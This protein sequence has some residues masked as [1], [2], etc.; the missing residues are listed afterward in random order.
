LGQSSTLKSW[1]VKRQQELLF[2]D[3]RDTQGQ[4]EWGSLY[5]STIK[6][7]THQGGKSGPTRRTFAKSGALNGT[8]DSN[9]RSILQDEPVFALSQPV[10]VSTTGSGTALFTIAHVQDL[11]VQFAS[12]P[13]TVQQLPPLWSSSYSSHQDLLEF[14]YHD[15]SGVTTTASQFNTQI[16]N[17]AYQVSSAQGSNFAQI[18]MLAARQ[19]LGGVAF[20]GT[21]DNTL[22]FLKE[23]SSDGNMQTVDVIFP[24]YPFFLYANPTWLQQL[25]EPLLI[26]QA[27]GLYPNKYSMHD[28]GSS[29][30]NGTGHPDGKDEYMPVEECGNMLIMGASV[31]RNFMDTYPGDVGRQ[32]AA[33][34][35]NGPGMNRYN[36]WKQWTGYLVEFSL[37]PANQCMYTIVSEFKRMWA[38]EIASEHG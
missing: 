24:S 10:Q 23:I 30:P 27:A 6:S 26:H 32:K 8:V 5:L 20:A 28:L 35:I 33:A 7:A 18:L 17:A 21:P 29:Y 1:E 37:L 4:A 2:S 16:N 25:L 12:A 13:N 9:F 34:W 3:A 15:F 22:I 36:L 31:V 19:V 38:D 11:L 14:H